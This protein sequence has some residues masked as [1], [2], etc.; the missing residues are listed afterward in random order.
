MFKRIF[1]GRDAKPSPDVEEEEE[2]TIKDRPT[3]IESS[4]REPRYKREG[5]Y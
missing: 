5:L 4:R 2:Q 3:K 1:F